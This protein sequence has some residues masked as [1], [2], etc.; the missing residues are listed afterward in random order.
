MRV[1]PDG[2]VIPAMYLRNVKRGPLIFGYS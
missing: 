1:E 2:T